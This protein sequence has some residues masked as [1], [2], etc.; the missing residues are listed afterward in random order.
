MD[1]IDVLIF[2]A[3]IGAFLWALMDMYRKKEDGQDK[4]FHWRSLKSPVVSNLELFNLFN[5]VEK[6]EDKEDEKTTP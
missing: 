3:F 4:S 6:Q 1:W 5:P 2:T